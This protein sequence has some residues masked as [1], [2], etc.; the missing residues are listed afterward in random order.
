MGETYDYEPDPRDFEPEP[1][2]IANGGRWPFPTKL[3]PNRP[4]PP[5]PFN[6]NN[7]EE[8]PL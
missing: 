1:K 2:W 6:P 8:S 4:I 5:M 3:P 7:H